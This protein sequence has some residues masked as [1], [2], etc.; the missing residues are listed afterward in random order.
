M[1]VQNPTSV[2]P[3]LSNETYIDDFTGT[4]DIDLQ[5][6]EPICRKEDPSKPD[7]KGV[8]FDPPI[9]S[10]SPYSKFN[11]DFSLSCSSS[12]A[13]SVS[14]SSDSSTSVSESEMESS[15]NHYNKDSRQVKIRKRKLSQNSD[16]TVTKLKIHKSTPNHSDKKKVIRKSEAKI[17]TKVKNQ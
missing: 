7:L 9:R 16:L 12:S 2:D 11:R 14:F 17:V 13:S 15:S 4:G 3:P 1:P 8:E 10:Y 5:L 6:I